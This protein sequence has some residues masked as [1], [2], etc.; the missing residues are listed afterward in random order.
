MAW[1]SINL[2]FPFFLTVNADVALP[3]VLEAILV[4]F[5]VALLIFTSKISVGSAR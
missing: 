2:Y 4:G 5:F 1:A 3:L